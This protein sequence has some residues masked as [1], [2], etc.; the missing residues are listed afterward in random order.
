MAEHERAPGVARVRVEPWGREIAAPIG[1]RLYEVLRGAGLPLGGSCG[2][3][4]ICAACGVRVL[5]GDPG[6]EGPLERRR[7]AENGVRAE[8]RLTCLVRLKGDLT[9]RAPYW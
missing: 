4:G 2:G 9:V 6:P 1:D 5:A 7:K 3:E 8:L